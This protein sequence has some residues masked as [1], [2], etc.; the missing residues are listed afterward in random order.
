MRS[1]K[2]SGWAYAALA[3]SLLVIGGFAQAAD[4]GR[5]NLVTNPGFES[6]DNDG[7]PSAWRI[8]QGPGEAVSVER[9]GAADGKNCIH[10]KL[11]GEVIRFH[12]EKEFP[13]H[14]GLV[15][16][17]RAK[18]KTKAF[19]RES[20][21]GI[22]LVN[23]G[24]TWGSPPLKVHVPHSDWREY[25]VRFRV[26]PLAG[27]S[28]RARVNM[29]WSGDKGEVWIDA[30][31]LEPDETDYQ[32]PAVL[33]S[34]GPAPGLSVT[35]DAPNT[36]T[37]GDMAL[38]TVRVNAPGD[39]PRD[40]GE[41]CSIDRVE[42]HKFEENTGGQYMSPRFQIAKIINPD[43]QAKQFTARFMLTSPEPG[44]QHYGLWV[45]YR[46]KWTRFSIE[47]TRKTVPLGERTT[48]DMAAGLPTDVQDSL[49]YLQQIE[50]HKCSA[51]PEFEL[52]KKAKVR[53]LQNKSE[54]ISA[55]SGRLAS[56]QNPDLAA[57][58][59]KTQLP[60]GPG[61]VPGIAAYLVHTT[62][63]ENSGRWDVVTV[64]YTQR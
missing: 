26:P 63:I 11:D 27:K 20:S 2:T 51:T 53:L 25:R 56:V 13:I 48:V 62:R 42:L 28:R 32:I 35:V 12:Q 43:K 55:R 16:T 46:P 24:W 23:N 17:L 15:Y 41:G 40:K 18:V 52:D 50:L 58:V 30:L 29:Y 64:H 8:S 5:A 6:L 4:T 39:G 14:P 47:V 10:F 34:G 38:V 60:V 1:T 31:R 7:M 49:N 19:Q 21:Y 33:T 59:F 54:L 36:M 9:T 45:G 61:N 22:L 3:M 44:T 37:T 57:P